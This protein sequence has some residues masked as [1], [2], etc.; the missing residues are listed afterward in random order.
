MIADKAILLYEN[1]TKRFRAPPI[2]DKTITF[3][4]L[5]PF[6]DNILISGC[7]SNR[8]TTQVLHKGVILQVKF[9]IFTN[10]F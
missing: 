7:T 4:M 9:R 2:D 1:W 6:N 8:K 10:K 3:S 5:F